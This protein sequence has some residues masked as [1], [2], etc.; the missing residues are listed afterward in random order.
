MYLIVCLLCGTGHQ[1]LYVGPGRGQICWQIPHFDRA[2]L[3]AR[4][5]ERCFQPGHTHTVRVCY[6]NRSVLGCACDERQ[7]WQQVHQVS[8]G[9]GDGAHSVGVV[10]ALSH[11]AHLTAVLLHLPHTHWSVLEAKLQHAIT[12]VVLSVIHNCWC[13][14]SASAY[15]W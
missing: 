13:T 9:A 6:V 4:R 11:A 15:L 1:P 14:N 7:M 8:P 2:V 12:I 3:T 5:Y 10:A